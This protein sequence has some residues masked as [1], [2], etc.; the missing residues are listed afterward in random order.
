LHASL[1]DA[2]ML[3]DRGLG[4][5][6]YDSRSIEEAVV[7]RHFER[8]SANIEA[9]V[10]IEWMK[11][12]ISALEKTVENL[13]HELS[14]VKA[15]R[16]ELD[17]IPT[18]PKLPSDVSDSKSDKLPSFLKDNPWVDILGRRGREPDHVAS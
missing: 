17:A 1:L 18:Q 4:L 14:T 8:H 10:D 2:S 5:L 13:A 12:R 6:V 16:I 3:Q 9:D 11:N 15:K 7:P